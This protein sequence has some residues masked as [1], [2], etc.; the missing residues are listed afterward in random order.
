MQIAVVSPCVLPAALRLRRHVQGPFK[1]F[2]CQRLDKLTE[3]GEIVPSAIH[4]C[5]VL[6]PCQSH[7]FP[8]RQHP[9]FCHASLTFC[10]QPQLVIVRRC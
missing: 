7:T 4:V 9:L 1:K 5:V 10:G 2:Q 3:A 8:A 6:L